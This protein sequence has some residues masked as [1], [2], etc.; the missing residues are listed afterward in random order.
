MKLSFSVKSLG[1]KN[2]YIKKL[3]IELN[4]YNQISVQTLLTKI[5]E[6]QVC[7][8]NERKKVDNLIEF[9]APTA[10]TEAAKLGKVHFNEQYNNV[11]ANE[12]KAIATV[13]QA[14]ADGLIALFLNEIQLESL[15]EEITIKELDSIQIIRLAFLAGSIW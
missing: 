12:E 14:F 1:K 13:H 4:L 3:I 2:A 15:E 5:V 9:I 7:V 10:I 8:F 11:A 6:H